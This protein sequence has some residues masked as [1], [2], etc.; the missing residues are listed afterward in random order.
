MNSPFT[1]SQFAQHHLNLYILSSTWNGPHWPTYALGQN[2]TWLNADEVENRRFAFI[3]NAANGAV[4]SGG[5]S[6]G[7]GMPWWVMVDCALMPAGFF[8]VMGPAKLLS[9]NKRSIIN[10][11]LADIPMPQGVND[12]SLIAPLQ[13]D[14]IIPLAEASTLACAMPDKIS[15]YSLYSLVPGLAIIAKSLSL[16]AY[17]QLGRSLQM[18]I[19]Q[20]DNKSLRIHTQFGPLE[21]MNFAVPLHTYSER[22]FYYRLEIPDDNHLQELLGGKTLKSKLPA[23]P[24]MISVT[25]VA[26]RKEFEKR[27]AAGTHRYYLAAPGLTD[28]NQYNPIIEVETK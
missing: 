8:G 15:S 13:D 3:L 12:P 10:K 23:A 11:I 6:L 21:I 7:I 5:V 22:T 17:K 2:V 19:A 25:D 26:K 16:S 14:E 1:L 4:Y 24:Q 18:G 27:R 28:D 20:Y 9:D